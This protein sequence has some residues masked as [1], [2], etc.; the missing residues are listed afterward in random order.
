MS[1]VFISSTHTLEN[2]PLR[3][4]LD[5][6]SISRSDSPYPQRIRFHTQCR[7]NDHTDRHCKIPLHCN[8]PLFV[9]SGVVVEAR[10]CPASY[11]RKYKNR[12]VDFVYHRLSVIDCIYHRPFSYIPNVY[13]S[14]HNVVST[15]IPIAIAKFLYIETIPF[16]LLLVLWLKQGYVLPPTPESTKIVWSTLYIIDYLSLI[17]CTIDRYPI[18]P[19]VYRRR[20]A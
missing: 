7:F 14:I 2:M 1:Y 9:A 12:L 4:A 6:V 10:I 19:N 20:Q 5:P 8:H 16:L 3:Y 15:T 11:P 13:D 18:S 17:V